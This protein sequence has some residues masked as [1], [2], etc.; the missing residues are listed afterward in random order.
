[1]LTSKQIATLA[2]LGVIAL[3]VIDC[4]AARVLP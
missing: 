4:L 3:A 1:M 2:M